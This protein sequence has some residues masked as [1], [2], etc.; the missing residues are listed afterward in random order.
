MLLLRAL[1]RV[2]GLE[3]ATLLLIEPVLNPIWSWIIHGERP[4]VLTLAGGALIVGVAFAGTVW[5][6]KFTE[7][8]QLHDFPVPD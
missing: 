1:R 3:A 8:P 6:L 4:G 7:V 5:R 2:P